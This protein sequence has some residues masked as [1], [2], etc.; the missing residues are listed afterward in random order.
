M[1]NEPIS[2][3]IREHLHIPAFRDIPA[4]RASAECRRADALGTVLAGIEAL[5]NMP[6]DEVAEIL[7]ALERADRGEC[8]VSLQQAREDAESQAR[9]SV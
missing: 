6:P 9:V 5:S 3:Y 4:E 2:A 1:N 8:S 7:R